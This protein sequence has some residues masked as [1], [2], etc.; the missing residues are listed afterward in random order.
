MQIAV[1]DKPTEQILRILDTELLKGLPL[2]NVPNG[3][4]RDS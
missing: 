3:H 4:R 1:M 2:W